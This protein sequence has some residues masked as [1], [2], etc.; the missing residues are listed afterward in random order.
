MP[1]SHFLRTFGQFAADAPLLLQHMIKHTLINAG[2]DGG[3]Q[4]IGEHVGGQR[5]GLTGLAGKGAPVGRLGW[6]CDRQDAPRQS[7]SL[8]FR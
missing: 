2:F 8:I 5:L 1:R 3:A 6:R 4:D 7:T